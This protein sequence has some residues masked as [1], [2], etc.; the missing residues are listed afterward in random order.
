MLIVAYSLFPNQ[1]ILFLKQ[2]IISVARGKPLIQVGFKGTHEDNHTT[3]LFV[4][5]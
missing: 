2:L 1:V 5:Q 4:P 3:S